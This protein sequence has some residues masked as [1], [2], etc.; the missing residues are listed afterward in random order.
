MLFHTAVFSLAVCAVVKWN[1]IAED[2]ALDG[3]EIQNW[4]ENC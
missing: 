3:G 1:F 2:D 4:I